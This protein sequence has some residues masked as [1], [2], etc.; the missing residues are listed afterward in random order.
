MQQACRCHE[1]SGSSV[2]TQTCIPGD[3]S[4]RNRTRDHI[5][6]G[7][8]R[9][10]A[11]TQT[12]KTGIPA[13]PGRRARHQVLE[14]RSPTGGHPQGKVRDANCAGQPQTG[15]SAFRL[16]LPGPALGNL[17]LGAALSLVSPD[18]R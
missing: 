10:T 7:T 1:A 18:A 14:V 6:T 16:H 4:R 15:T 11:K 9:E 12:T 3:M 17:R 13:C 8:Q 5:L 2:L